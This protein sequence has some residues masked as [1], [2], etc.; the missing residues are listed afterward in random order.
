MDPQA[1]QF[2]KVLHESG[3]IQ[4]AA[5]RLPVNEQVEIAVLVGIPARDGTEHSHVS[6]T[7]PCSKVED[8]LGAACSQRTERE[9]KPIV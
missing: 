3:M 8:L 2:L 7:A 6:G 4:K 1:Q 5:P 9:H